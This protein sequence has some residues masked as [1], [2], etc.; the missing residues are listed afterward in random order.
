[1]KKKI[2][3]TLFL[4][5]MFLS[6][7]V[8]TELNLMSASQQN[9][10]SKIESGTEST[11]ILLGNHLAYV[12]YGILNIFDMI[13]WSIDSSVTYIKCWI[14]TQSNFDDFMDGFSYTYYNLLGTWTSA[15]TFASYWRIDF[16]ADW[17][18]VFWNDN[19]ETTVLELDISLDTLIASAEIYDVNPYSQDEDS[20]V[21]S[22]RVE[23][24]IRF[25]LMDDTSVT[26]TNMDEFVETKID[27][28]DENGKLIRTYEDTIYVDST[29]EYVTYDF[30][31]VLATET[32]YFYSVR[33]KAC[34]YYGSFDYPDSSDTEEIS[35][36]F[37]PLDW[38]KTLKR[39]LIIRRSL[40]W[41]S[42]GLVVIA[43]TITLV[44]IS[45]KKKRIQLADVPYTIAEEEP[46]TQPT[47]PPS[48]ETLFC[49]SCGTANK[50]NSLFCIKCGSEL[51]KPK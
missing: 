44:V 32:S 49:W 17:V 31:N 5:S 42:I 19:P 9:D 22:L 4:L 16:T 3:T 36:Q 13:D 24:Y 1:M 33:I 10:K 38:A 8:K 27:L 21:D 23:Y 47:D 28:I 34:F 41:G 7:F 11:H 29:Y 39:K 12:D 6:M 48:P 20:Y 45:K 46:I 35:N 40:I 37:Y 50:Q 18:V 15:K 2:F 43:T 51:S 14:M 25:T 26:F 30:G